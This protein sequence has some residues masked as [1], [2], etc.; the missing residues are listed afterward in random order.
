MCNVNRTFGYLLGAVLLLSA[1]GF[2]QDWPQWRGANRDGKVLGF[3]AP[4]NAPDKLA[5]Q[6]KV[7]V[8]AG[9]ASPVLVGEKLYV[10][11]RL[12]EQET[13][14]CLSAIDGKQLWQ[15]HYAAPPVTGAAA[16]HQGPR[17]TPA[18]AQGKVV[19]LG[20]CGT[21]SC[22]DA[23]TG[24][25]LW[26]KDE[27]PN[28]YPMFFTS[29]SPLITDGLA[30]AQLGSKDQGGIIAYDLT[31]GDVKWR[32]LGEG[33]DYASPALMTVAKTKQI[34]TLTNKSLVG[35]GVADGKLLWTIPFAPLSRAYNA[36]TPI[37]DGQTVIYT[38]AKRGTHAVKIDKQ[39]DLF[40]PTELWSNPDVAVQFNSPVLK[41]GLLYGLSDHGNL[42]CLDAKTGKTA[43][44]DTAQCDKGGFCTI[45]DVGPAMLAAPS[46]GDLI[47]FK[48]DASAYGEVARYKIADTPTY[49]APL[50]AGNRL[51]VK[52][53]D[54]VILWVVK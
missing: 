40:T 3:T 37:I 26:R 48:P 1:A 27:F 12:N 51:F 8:G 39:G 17:G 41:D 15:D 54:S 45:L 13:T 46:N 14:S 10:F 19:T 47:A 9:D 16:K 43:W 42:F 4:Q 22:L 24:K 30:I 18:V 49:A 31:T 53:Q 32:W 28:I 29:M 50:I 44:I 33:P 11:T 38:G 6:W 23:A 25:L 21:V 2:A 36:A 34:V 35:V 52:D 20:A 5:Q 7:T